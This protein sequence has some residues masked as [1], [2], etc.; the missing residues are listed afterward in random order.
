[1]TP[2]GGVF[3][4]CMPEC[5]SCKLD[6]LQEANKYL[7]RAVNGFPAAIRTAQS[8]QRRKDVE[9]A[10]RIGI[11]EEEPDPSSDYER[12]MHETA[13]N[14]ADAILAQGE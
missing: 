11:V 7:Q 3:H 10:K 6:R 2:D 1:M 5:N 12:G 4:S 13:I 9:I 8:E 14:I